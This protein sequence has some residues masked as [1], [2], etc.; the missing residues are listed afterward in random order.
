MCLSFLLRPLCTLFGRSK[1]VVHTVFKL[2]AYLF[3]T[4]FSITSVTTILCLQE[5]HEGIFHL[6]VVSTIVPLFAIPSDG[7]VIRILEGLG[8]VFEIT[9]I[10]IY[11]K[12]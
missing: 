8:P 2:G 5:A 11:T 12:R 7:V 4:A 3:G 6:F 1:G 9:L 10:D